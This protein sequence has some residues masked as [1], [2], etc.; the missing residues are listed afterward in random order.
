MFLSQVPTKAG[1]NNGASWERGGKHLFVLDDTYLCSVTFICLWQFYKTEIYQVVLSYHHARSACG[2]C[3]WG[4]TLTS[5]FHFVH[6]PSLELKWL[7]CHWPSEVVL[8][9]KH[10]VTS[11]PLFFQTSDLR[12]QGLQFRCSRPCENGRKTQTCLCFIVCRWS[13]GAMSTSRKNP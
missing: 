4:G 3:C 10:R 2:S 1:W 8:A 5:L 7:R 12:K 13:R 11:V 6:S 9:H